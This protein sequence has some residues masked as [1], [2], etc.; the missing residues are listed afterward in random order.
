MSTITIGTAANNTL[1]GLAFEPGGLDPAD[2][3]TIAQ[4]I[5][6]D[7]NPGAAASRVVPG[8]FQRAQLVIPNRGILTILPGDVIAY[9]P[10]TGFPYLISA[11]AAAGA[12]WVHS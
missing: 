12:S 11:L 6:F 1:I 9:D 2:V 7:Q 3:A 10:A 8:A 5:I 4:H